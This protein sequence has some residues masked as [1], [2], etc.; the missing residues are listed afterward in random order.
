MR[1]IRALLKEINRVLRTDFNLPMV[2]QSLLRERKDVTARIRDHEFRERIFCS[3]ADLSAMC[4][5]L[6]VSPQVRDAA[7]QSKRDV[8]VLKTFQRQVI[9]LK[10]LLCNSYLINNYM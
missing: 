2:V 4:M 9:A 10:F 6:C 1:S 5:L 3:L 7:T 8:S